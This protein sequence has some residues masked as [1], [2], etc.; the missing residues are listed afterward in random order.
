VIFLKFKIKKKIKKETRIEMQTNP[1]HPA[2]QEAIKARQAAKRRRMLLFK[3]KYRH[4]TQSR[5]W[6]RDCKL[7]W[8]EPDEVLL[9]DPVNLLPQYLLLLSSIPKT[10]LPSLKTKEDFEKL[11]LPLKQFIHNNPVLYLDER[12]SSDL[13]SEIILFDS[14]LVETLI[15][16]GINP[17]FVP[18]KK[19]KFSTPLTYLFDVMCQDNNDPWYTYDD[20]DDY[21]YPRKKP[22]S[23]VPEF[24]IKAYLKTFELLIKSGAN[25]HELDICNS[26]FL[27]KIIQTMTRIP[28]TSTFRSVALDMIR[29]VIDAG[30]DVNHRNNSE[31]VALHSLC[32]A[33]HFF[34]ANIRDIL[35][36]LLQHK[37][38]DIN[39]QDG[40]GD[41][42]FH[43]LIM[44]LGLSWFY[45]NDYADEEQDYSEECFELFLDAKV[46]VTLK[47]KDGETVLDVFLK[48]TNDVI[49][50]YNSD[51]E[52]VLDDGTL[53][54]LFDA[55][56]SPSYF[57][58]FLEKKGFVSIATK[59]MNY[60]YSL[61]MEK[62]FFDIVSKSDILQRWFN[63]QK[64]DF[65]QRCNLLN[66]ES[67]LPQRPV[68]YADIVKEIKIYF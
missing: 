7:L 20:D 59:W 10:L 52:G 44:T 19:S 23:I 33:V 1:D 43:R 22:K 11:L 42:S 2:R 13:L 68:I 40:D 60:Y 45:F 56:H 50:D 67:T 64:F 16:H 17:N 26:T 4:Q 12:D 28:K 5:N 32:G 21:F 53:N 27:Q 37:N 9:P 63:K 3:E 31:I 14:E 57:P 65:W 15:S 66:F 8:K 48:Y 62:E 30:I 54:S 25:V 18:S 39:V 41:T 29:I 24:V 49:N 6:H 36:V 38:I 47:N 35:K 61:N 46:D 51:Q 58:N 34:S 55:D